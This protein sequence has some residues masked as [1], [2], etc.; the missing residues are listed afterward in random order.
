MLS[1]KVVSN[2]NLI[3]SI[4]SPLCVH[5]GLAKYFSTAHNNLETK[6]SFESEKQKYFHMP[7]EEKRQFY[8][9]GMTTIDQILSWT[10]Y[11]NK[12]KTNIGVTTLEKVEKVNT[13]LADKISLWQGDITSLEIDAIVNAANSSLLGGGG[14]DG[15]IHRAAGPNLKKECATL[16]GCHVGEAKITG[17]YLLPA[18]YVIHTVG[19]QGEHPDKLR[20]CY[21]SCL[22][23][24]KENQLRT[25]AFPCISTGVYGY[26]QRPAAKV[27]LATVKKFLL[28]DKD[29]FDRIIFCV[30]LP[31][32]KD[33]YEELLQKYFGLE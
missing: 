23:V 11:W 15:A 32:D 7:I 28:D 33:I 21:K 20:E 17:G 16:G 26:P 10:D 25:I 2:G 4:L 18:K 3:K 6:M 24:A 1:L 13:E 30:F 29:Q 9:T 31:S 5:S 8:K 12:N 14:V 27:A 22:A 19:P